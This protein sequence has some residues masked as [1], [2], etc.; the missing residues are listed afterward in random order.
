MPT[1]DELE[2]ENK[3]L[4]AKIQELTE[5]IRERQQSWDT[6]VNTIE[7]PAGF[8]RDPAIPGGVL[9]ATLGG[10]V[11]ISAEDWINIVGRV[12]VG[13]NNGE[14]H[15]LVRKVHLG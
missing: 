14:N 12:S 11:P 6:L 4:V 15:A 13:G 5:Q 3:A 9:L 7:E 10:V 1:K 2:Q 8:N